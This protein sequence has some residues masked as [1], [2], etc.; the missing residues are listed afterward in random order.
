MQVT[1]YQEQ[2]QL[3]DPLLE[4]LV[5]PLAGLLHRFALD[6]AAAD[7]AAVTDASRFLWLLATVRWGAVRLTGTSSQPPMSFSLSH[8]V[9]FYYAGEACT[10]ALSSPCCCCCLQGLQGGAALLPQRGG[11][12]GAGGGAAEAAGRGGER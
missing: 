1:K 10:S 9:R 6:P 4:G 5:Q 11:Q 3:L 8:L 7:P 2:A 12:L